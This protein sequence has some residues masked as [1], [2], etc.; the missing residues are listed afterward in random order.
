VLGGVLVGLAALI[1]AVLECFYVNLRIGRTPVPFAQVVAMLGNLGLPWAMAKLTGR[2]GTAIIPALL[3]GVIAIIFAASGPGGDV[4]VPGNWQGMF[5]LL[6]GAGAAVLSI[7]VL[8]QPAGRAR[9]HDHG[10]DAPSRL[11][12]TPP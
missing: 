7:V 5:L 6:G 4:V 2:R 3:W 12:T 10:A 8:V 11:G 1:L 9:S